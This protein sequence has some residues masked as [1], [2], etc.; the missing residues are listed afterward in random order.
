M[1]F[2]NENRPEVFAAEGFQK[3]STN[4]PEG[5]LFLQNCTYISGES[6]EAHGKN[7][8]WTPVKH[9]YRSQPR[10]EVPRIVHF[11]RAKKGA[12]IPAPFKMQAIQDYQVNVAP[13]RMEREICHRFGMPYSEFRCIPEAMAVDCALYPVSAAW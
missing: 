1:T 4:V 12:G 13:K 7:G 6:S 11:G 2:R 10:Q 5:T 9:D 8:L 3:F